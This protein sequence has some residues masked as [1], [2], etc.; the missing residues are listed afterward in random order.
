MQKLWQK[1]YVYTVPDHF[2]LCLAKKPF[3]KLEYK[4]G[5]P[6]LKKFYFLL[7]AN[8]SWEFELCVFI[9]YGHF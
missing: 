6:L 7:K 9:P 8:S 3:L 2:S 5:Y 1:M 4:W